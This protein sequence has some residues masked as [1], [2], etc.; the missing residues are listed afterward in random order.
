MGALAALLCSFSLANLPSV[1]FGLSLRYGTP[2][3]QRVGGTSGEQPDT[4]SLMHKLLPPVRGPRRGESFLPTHRL[5]EQQAA[6]LPGVLPWSCQHPAPVL[7]LPLAAGC[8]PHQGA[9]LLE[10]LVNTS[11]VSWHSAPNKPSQSCQAATGQSLGCSITL[12]C[13]F[14]Q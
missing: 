9:T 6:P 14:S 8:P 11:L 4:C 1:W 7:V 2:A 13:C 5:M 3:E 10:N 12:L